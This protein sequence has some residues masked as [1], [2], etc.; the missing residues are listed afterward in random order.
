MIAP[1]CADLAEDESDPLVVGERQ[2][3]QI[4]HQ[5]IILF[6]FSQWLSITLKSEVHTLQS[7]EDA[8]TISRDLAEG[9][10][11]QNL[12]TDKCPTFIGLS[13]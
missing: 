6:M 10:L 7:M 8:G 2:R 3:I 5:H 11:E 9:A 4:P 12:R 1:Y 13:L